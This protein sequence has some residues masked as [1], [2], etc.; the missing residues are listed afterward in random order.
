M[1]Y[2]LITRP[3][4]CFIIIII[5]VSRVGLKDFIGADIGVNVRVK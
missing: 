4:N 2:N 3:P 5:A 1:L